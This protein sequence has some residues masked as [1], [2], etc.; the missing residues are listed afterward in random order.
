MIEKIPLIG[1][2][3][4][5]TLNRQAWFH[6]FKHRP[7]M[8][9]LW[10]WAS[11][12]PRQVLRKE[13]AFYRRLLGPLRTK[14]GII[15]DI[16]ANT[17]LL[18]KVFADYARTVV[19]V[20]PEPSNI[21][22]LRSHVRWKRQKVRVVEAACGA[23]AGVQELMV[24]SESGALNTFR[25]QWKEA[26][27]AGFLGTIPPFSGKRLAVPVTTLDALIRQYGPPVF[28]KVDVEG[29]EWEVFQG[30]SQRIPL[31]VF[32]ANLPV[33]RTETIRIVERL[34]ML[35][36]GATFNYA[37]D[38]DLQLRDYLPADRFIETLSQLEKASIDIVCR[39]TDHADAYP[40]G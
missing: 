23:E 30:L 28:L 14:D 26:L 34:S 19:A 27:E 11:P 9:W 22:V 2:P 10:M 35:D 37:D 8:L 5:R 36:T 17:G 6:R 32:E 29:Y 16:G 24:Y 18:T 20:E 31:L 38:F 39:G 13:A 25:P 12:G 4:R 15:L 21:A 40:G 1:P 7:F 3:L 33:F